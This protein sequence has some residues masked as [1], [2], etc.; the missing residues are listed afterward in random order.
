MQTPIS[1]ACGGDSRQTV[2]NPV[3]SHIYDIKS[4]FEN[5]KYR[6]AGGFKRVYEDLVAK[7]DGYSSEELQAALDYVPQPRE[8][9]LSPSEKR[10]FNRYL[11]AWDKREA[12]LTDEEQAKRARVLEELLAGVP[13]LRLEVIEGA[14]GRWGPRSC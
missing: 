12:E 6:H 4:V 9:H 8:P 10:W 5:P 11:K 1:D 7:F 2:N 3:F 13:T 14:A